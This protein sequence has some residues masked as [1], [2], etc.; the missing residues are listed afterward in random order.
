METRTEGA[1]TVCDLVDTATTSDAG[2]GGRE[3]EKRGV[4]LTS[5]EIVQVE[6]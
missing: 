4:A 3:H 5:V 6:I 1:W 2:C